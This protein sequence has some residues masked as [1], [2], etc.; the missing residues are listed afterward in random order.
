MA[1][2]LSR[3]CPGAEKSLKLSVPSSGGIQEPGFL[4]KANENVM[5]GRLNSNGDCWT[6]PEQ[7]EIWPLE[8]S[9]KEVS[10]SGENTPPPAKKSHVSGSRVLN[11]LWGGSEAQ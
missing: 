2:G 1:G 10:H 11:N 8:M 4:L 3:A 9:L 6:G 7:E 5:C